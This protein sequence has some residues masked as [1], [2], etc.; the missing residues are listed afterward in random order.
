VSEYSKTIAV[1][2]GDGDEIVIRMP[3]E[4]LACILEHAVQYGQ[5]DRNLAVLDRDELVEDVLD[6]INS[7]T[8]KGVTT[9]ES[10]FV[11]F[12]LF[13]LYAGSTA[14]RENGAYVKASVAAMA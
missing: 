6:E 1:R 12:A 13:A 5:H 11:Q 8:G 2:D 3:V 14:M 7:Y 9:M 10:L 4:R